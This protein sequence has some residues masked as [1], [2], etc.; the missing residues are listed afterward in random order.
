MRTVTAA[1]LIILVCSPLSSSS[2]ALTD[3]AE[4]LPWWE[5]TSMDEDRDGIHDAIWL[6]IGSDLHDWVDEDDTISVIV[7]F[8][9]Q[10]TAHDQ[11]MLE[12]E[13]GFQ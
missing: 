4:N 10:P 11:A 3:P 12:S 8:D 7:D 9:H 5:T 6:A 1:I 13:V 2:V